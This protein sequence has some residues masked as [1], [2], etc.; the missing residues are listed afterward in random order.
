MVIYLQLMFQLVK[1]YLKVS[2]LGQWDRQVD[3]PVPIFI[4]KSDLEGLFLTRRSF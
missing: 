4:L 3:P 2:R 1:Q